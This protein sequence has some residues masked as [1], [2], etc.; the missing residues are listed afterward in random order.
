MTRY[1]RQFYTRGRIQVYM[2]ILFFL[3]FLFTLLVKEKSLVRKNEMLRIRNWLYLPLMCFKNWGGSVYHHESR[4]Y[5][6]QTCASFIKSQFNCVSLPQITNPI[7]HSTV[8]SFLNNLWKTQQF[9]MIPNIFTENFYVTLSNVLLTRK[10][11]TRNTHD[12]CQRNLLNQTYTLFEY[13]IYLSVL[14]RRRGIKVTG[15]QRAPTTSSLSTDTN[16]RR[17]IKI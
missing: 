14:I 13:N 12:V 17:L 16:C 10:L 11:E 9:Q 2:C 6:T 3:V 4:S 5:F 8:V 1:F 15:G 7:Q